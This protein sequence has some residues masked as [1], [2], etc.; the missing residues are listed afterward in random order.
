MLDRMSKL[1]MLLSALLAIA[2]SPTR[3]AEG[4]VWQYKT[5]IQDAG[6]LIK[7][8]KIE[9]AE[10][11]TIYHISIIGI[12]LGPDASTPLQHAP[13]AQET[14]DASVTQQVPDPGTFPDA[15]EGIAEWRSA[16][17]GVFTISLAEIAEVLQK[18]VP[19]GRQPSPGPQPSPTS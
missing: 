2:A 1:L 19:P 7:I 6:S 10:R 5:R 18:T 4:Q 3:Y 8:Q 15:T 12:H 17:G 11:T 14:L 9:K 16:Q 13:V